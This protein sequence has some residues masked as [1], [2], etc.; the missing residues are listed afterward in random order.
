MHHT[1]IYKVVFKSYWSGMVYKVERDSDARSFPILPY[2]TSAVES[3]TRKR[4][5]HSEDGR[6][7]VETRN[8]QNPSPVTYIKFI[9]HSG[10]DFEEVEL[11]RDRDGPNKISNI[12][13]MSNRVFC[14]SIQA[15]NNLYSNSCCQYY[16]ITSRMG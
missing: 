10:L 7:S 8:P 2:P 1:C 6:M 13:Q 3:G 11:R 9:G 14:I 12:K 16:Y 4:I 15:T 5:L